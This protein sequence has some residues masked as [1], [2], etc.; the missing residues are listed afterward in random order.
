M[1]FEVGLTMKI[2]M[3]VSRRSEGSTLTARAAPKTGICV[4]ERQTALIVACNLQK[5]KEERC[6]LHNAFQ[7]RELRHTSRIPYPQPF[8]DCYFRK[9]NL[10]RSS[11]QDAAAS[12]P[13]NH[14][15]AAAA[16]RCP[17]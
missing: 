7:N 10:L 16:F 6:S 8:H 9:E 5:R 4:A 12:S 3:S 14:K 15:H 1:C 17:S 11:A 13:G 2:P